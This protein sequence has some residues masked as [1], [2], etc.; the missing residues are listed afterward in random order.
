M[1]GGGIGDSV[2]IES[3][4]AKRSSSYR[5]SSRASCE[6]G[7]ESLPPLAP[8]R[9]DHPGAIGGWMTARCC[10]AGA[11]VVGRSAC[12]TL[13]RARDVC[14]FLVVGQGSATWVRGQF[15]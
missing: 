15:S 3:G 8:W 14:V 9:A 6:P 10:G 5:R 13:N 7:I 1:T 4:G 11:R 2:V 12:D